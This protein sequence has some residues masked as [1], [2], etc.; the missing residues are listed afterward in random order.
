MLYDVVN[1]CQ[2]FKFEYLSILY[3]VHEIAMV[4]SRFAVERNN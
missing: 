2:Y 3:T 4:W 1:I